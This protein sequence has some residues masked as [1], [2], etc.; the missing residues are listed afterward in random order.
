MFR[1]NVVESQGQR[2]LGEIS[3]AQPFSI[4]AII[5]TIFASIGMILIF[6]TSSNYSRKETVKGYLIPDSGVIKVYPNRPGTLDKIYVEEGKAVKQGEV[7]AK[8]I[9]NRPQ[10]NGTDLSE[11]IISNLRQQQLLLDQD[12]LETQ[13]LL[14]RERDSLQK[15]IEDLELSIQS[16]ERQIQIL[17][18]QNEIK[19]SEYKRYE[20][21]SQKEFVSKIELQ[22][23]EQELLLVQEALESANENILLL[24]SKINDIRYKIVKI[25]HEM[26]LKK[27]KILREKTQIQLKIDEVQNNYTFNLIAKESGTVTAIASTEGESLQVSRP[28]L[29]IIPEGAELVAELFFPT[30]S[31]GFVKLND[32]AR[33]RFDAFPYQRFGFV[34]STITRIDKSLVSEGEIDAPIK[35]TEPVYRVRTKL[36]SQSFSAYGESFPLK[37]GMQVEADIILERRSLFQWLLDPIYSLH[38]RI[39]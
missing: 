13:S 4:Y 6:L 35:L 14:E 2:L 32:E 11:S 19:E 28:L 3:L 25:P 16:I 38:G 10:L 23:Q 15:K 8:I 18:K 39:S 1:K 27:T 12:L 7:L 30:R 29:S 26:R 37:V 20:L 24:S 9:L 31:A 34:E 5:I 21:L 22:S 33:L 36:I 17:T